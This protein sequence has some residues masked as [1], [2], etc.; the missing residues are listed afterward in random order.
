MGGGGVGGWIRKK[1]T[2]LLTMKGFDYNLAPIS[3]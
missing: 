2:L 3:K 1:E